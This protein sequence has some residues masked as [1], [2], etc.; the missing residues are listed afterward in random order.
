MLQ[1]A[2]RFG[3]TTAAQ[4]RNVMKGRSKNP[5]LLAALVEAEERNR[6]TEEKAKMFFQ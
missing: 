5:E 4:V 3:V 1:I 2:G 6:I